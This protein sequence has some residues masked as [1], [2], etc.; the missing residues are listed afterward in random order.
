[1]TVIVETVFKPIK[2]ELILRTSFQTRCQAEKSIGHYI[3]GF[4]NPVGCNS[5]LGFKSAICFEA[6]TAMAE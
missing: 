3:D 6:E 4:Y 5:A 2:S 1:M